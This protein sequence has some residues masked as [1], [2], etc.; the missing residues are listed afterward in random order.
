[1]AVRLTGIS[2]V[3]GEGL[4]ELVKS[5]S[6]KLSTRASNA[7]LVSRERDRAIF[8]L[9]V[10]RL[11][12]I[13]ELLD[14]SDDEILAFEIFGLVSSLEGVIGRVGVENILDEIFASFCLGK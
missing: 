14:S 10:D 2:A 13:L 8:D 3:S 4:D 11:E 5:I 7:G 12:E 6:E 1:M 9:A